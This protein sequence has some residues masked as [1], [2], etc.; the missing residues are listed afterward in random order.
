LNTKGVGAFAFYEVDQPEGFEKVNEAKYLKYTQK[1]HDWYKA[2]KYV[3]R[4]HEVG[5]AICVNGGLID[6]HRLSCNKIRNS[7]KTTEELFLDL[8]KNGFPID[9]QK[10]CDPAA[11]YRPHF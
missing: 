5:L 3:G 6:N 8:I 11:N 7:R 4:A 9:A 1:T 2:R 10:L